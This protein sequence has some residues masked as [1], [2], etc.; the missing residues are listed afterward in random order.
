MGNVTWRKHSP[1]FHAMH[2][3]ALAH[4]IAAPGLG[5]LEIL[6][7]YSLGFK[8]C[9]HSFDRSN[10]TSPTYGVFRCSIQPRPIAFESAGNS[11]HL[12]LGLNK[13][14]VLFAVGQFRDSEDDNDIVLL[15]G[16]LCSQIIN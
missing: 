14:S 7:Y 11:K 13:I 9:R 1:R 15:G 4:L 12:A 10:C 2:H 5:L 6:L 3:Y 16:M 8:R